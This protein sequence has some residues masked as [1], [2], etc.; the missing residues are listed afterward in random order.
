MLTP[1]EQLTS[2]NYDM[3]DKFAKEANKNNYILHL[4]IGSNEAG[5]IEMYSASVLERQMKINLLESAL[6]EL[7]HGRSTK[8]IIPG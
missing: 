8:I 6:A 3:C 1:K 7:K 5:K 4:A 2:H